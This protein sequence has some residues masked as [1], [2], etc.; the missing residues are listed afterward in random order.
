MLRRISAFGDTTFPALPA[1]GLPAVDQRRPR[2]PQPG[3]R[4]RPGQVLP[5]PRARGRA[6]RSAST[7]LRGRS[8]DGRSPRRV[9]YESGRGASRQEASDGRRR[10]AH[11][12]GRVVARR[13]P[14]PRSTACWLR[15]RRPRSPPSRSPTR[16]ERRRPPGTSPTPTHR[17]RSA[18]WRR[19]ARPAATGRRSMSR[20]AN[21]GARATGISVVSAEDDRRDLS[22]RTVLQGRHLAERRHP[23]AKPITTPHA[24]R[25]IHT[26][27]ERSS[28][29]NFVASPSIA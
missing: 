3:A 11:A 10:R 12:G 8:G 6:S 23:A 27:F 20:P 22:R 13:A 7:S 19:R 25:L 5:L 26:S 24:T 28:E 29:K 2:P 21:T 16:R 4:A 17:R 9:R 18:G 15:F 14:C 1:K